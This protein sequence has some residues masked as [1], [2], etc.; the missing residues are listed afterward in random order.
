MIFNPPSLEAVS[1]DTMH[2][3]MRLEGKSLRVREVELHWRWH[4]ESGKAGDETL[5]RPLLGACAAEDDMGETD[6]FNLI[7]STFDLIPSEAK[8]GNG[9]NGEWAQVPTEAIHRVRKTR[10]YRACILVPRRKSGGD[11]AS[12]RVLQF[13]VRGRAYVGWGPWSLTSD[14]LTTLS[15][16]MPKPSAVLLKPRMIGVRWTCPAAEGG[17]HY[18][19]LLR[20]TVLV[21]RKPPTGSSPASTG[22][23]KS[24]ASVVHSSAPL[25]AE[26]GRL[27]PSTMYQIKVMAQFT[28]SPEDGSTSPSKRDPDLWHP[29]RYRSTLMSEVL[30]CS[31]GYGDSEPE[32]PSS[33][34]AKIALF[35]CVELTWQSPDNNGHVIEKYTVFGRE[36][37]EDAD[38]GKTGFLEVWSGL[39]CMC[40]LVGKVG[41]AE[42][43]R[44][45]ISPGR[46][47]QFK[48]NATNK[49]G[50]GNFSKVLR[51]ITSTDPLLAMIES[52]PDSPRDERRGSTVSPVNDGG[53]GGEMKEDRDPLE[54]S[55]S[56]ISAVQHTPANL[57]NLPDGWVEC[58]D[59]TNQ[60][61]YYYNP[62]KGSQ[63]ND[64]R[65]PG[66][67]DAGGKVFRA[68]RFKLFEKLDR[69]I[70]SAASGPGS[71]A[72]PGS[73]GGGGGGRSSPTAGG[74][75]SPTSLERLHLKVRRK[76]I[77]ED[78][79]EAIFRKPAKDLRRGTHVQFAGE[80]G[81]DSGGLTYDW[82]LQCSRQLFNAQLCL[83]TP[84]PGDK[85]LYTID[86][87]SGVNSTHL[88]YFRF[89]GRLLG[90]AIHGGQIVYCPLS[91]CILKS[92]LGH[93]LMLTDLKDMDQVYYASLKWMNESDI[94]DVI[95]E[96]FSVTIE[97][98]G[99]NK[100]VDLIPNGRDVTVTE[101]NKHI[102]VEAATNFRAAG[103][104]RAQLGSLLQGLYD[105]VPKSAITEF[106]CDELAL[107]LN[108]NPE[109][110][111]E[112]L[113]SSTK[114][115]GGYNDA[116]KP[117]HF[118][119]EAFQQC[120]QKEQGAVIEFIT[121]SDRVPI[122]GFNPPFTITK[123]DL[124]AESLP[125]S[126]TCFNQLVLPPYSSKK[127]L[128]SKLQMAVSNSGGFHLT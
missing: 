83:F 96:T 105:V 25:E 80:D 35:D 15:A 10:R 81:I 59:P 103:A 5:R 114:L 33:V 26:L 95:F 50:A 101:L 69:A 115:S 108:G 78:S 20:Y 123:S 79:F 66:F 73:T 40:K 68:K 58:W 61:C 6:G 121:G 116:S 32:V 34:R 28:C 93:P 77:L 117:V 107:L 43:G 82:F 70:Q 4:P 57:V 29:S 16:E 88:K 18:G 100:V 38:N 7:P 87:R 110:N 21:R 9:E 22:K 63:W 55:S 31:T 44:L 54:E 27:R 52:P 51:L 30:T 126:H 14:A 13:R 41:T 74:P 12:G 65:G 36:V 24:A 17:A 19:R 109:I 46:G 1:T 127:Q 98:F 8:E 118:F 128:Q 48:V 60:N 104:I 99:V 45:E 90:M 86:P 89:A 102:Y 3:S 119:W 42:T 113:R 11:D 92:M 106:S 111:H 37:S 124:G 72:S 97:E 85:D 122:D 64:P 53:A 56:S 49:V 71:P 125:R 2:V 94:T 62:S 75:S 120:S 112:N 23:F 84:L 47:Y 76:S 39:A 91:N 67:E